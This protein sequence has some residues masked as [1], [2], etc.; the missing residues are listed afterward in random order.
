MIKKLTIALVI[1][2]N[3]AFA[4]ELETGGGYD[5]KAVEKAEYE[6]KQKQLANAKSK[7]KKA[8]KAR[9]LKQAE[10]VKKSLL[11]DNL[12]KLNDGELCIKAGKYNDKPELDVILAEAKKRKLSYDENSIKS[13]NIKIDGFMCDVFAVFG[14]PDRYN[15]TVTKYGTKVQFV[16]GRSYIYTEN[17]VITAWSD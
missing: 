11:P 15:R 2:S 8:K 1:T 12:A 5:Y 3:L 7:A 10:D 4:E 16:Y 9:L 6:A 14:R 17:N 13:K